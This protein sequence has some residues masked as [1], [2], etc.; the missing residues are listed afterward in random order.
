MRDVQNRERDSHGAPLRDATAQTLTP[1]VTDGA[2]LRTSV[3]WQTLSVCPDVHGPLTSGA[4][5]STLQ[6][7]ESVAIAHSTPVSD[8]TSIVVPALLNPHAR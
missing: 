3:G 2:D 7:N 5:M 4:I 1:P 8:I 6:S